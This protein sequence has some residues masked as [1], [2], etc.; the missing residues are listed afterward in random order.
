MSMQDPQNRPFSVAS[1]QRKLDKFEEYIAEVTL[2]DHD[3]S[4]EEKRQIINGG[5]LHFSIKWFRM[6]EKNSR[7]IE[8]ECSSL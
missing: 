5:F 7:L 2:Q 4:T 6:T 1:F 3:V 8:S